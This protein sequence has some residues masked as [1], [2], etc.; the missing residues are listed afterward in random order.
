MA[1]FREALQ[2]TRHDNRINDSLASLM[3]TVAAHVKENPKAAFDS[4]KGLE[5]VLRELK[6]VRTAAGAGT[7][8]GDTIGGSAISDIIDLINGI[9]GVLK[10]EKDF[11]LQIIKLIFCGC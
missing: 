4:G 11:F 3:E 6:A 10:D 8:G 9:V 5:D 1:L 2:F 7:T